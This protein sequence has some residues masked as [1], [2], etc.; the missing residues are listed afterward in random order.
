MKQNEIRRAVT[1]VY[2]ELYSLL[3]LYEETEGF[4]T[5][6][7]GEDAMDLARRKLSGLRSRAEFLANGAQK[8]VLYKGEMRFLV[9]GIQVRLAEDLKRVIGETEYFIRQYERPGVVTRWKQLDPR[10]VYYDCA[11]EIMEKFPDEYRKMQRGLTNILLPCCPDPEMVREREEYFAQIR[12]QCEREHREYSE[13]R[14]FQEE[15]LCALSL[16][17]A[18]TFRKYFP[19]EETAKE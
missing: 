12:E 19:E 16:V 3:S 6:H 9:D 5:F 2:E 11:F 7:A 15:L 8:Q 13:S 18:D 17:F 4:Q 1:E 14:A 10:L